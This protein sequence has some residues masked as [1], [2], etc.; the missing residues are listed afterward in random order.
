MFYL[1]K[2]TVDI[3]IAHVVVQLFL[4]QLF[5]IMSTL[6]YQWNRRARNRRQISTSLD[7]TNNRTAGPLACAEP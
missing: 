5:C 3:V 2:K 4:M 7:T 1:N 6:K